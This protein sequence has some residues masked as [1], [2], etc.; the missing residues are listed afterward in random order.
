[1]AFFDLGELHWRGVSNL[2][3]EDFD[4]SAAKGRLDLWIYG[5]KDQLGKVDEE[6]DQAAHEKKKTEDYW[7]KT[8]PKPSGSGVQP[9]FD[10]NTAYLCINQP[11]NV[12]S[13]EENVCL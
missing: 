2:L 10:E 11:I 1:M 3:S 9:K 6:K 8:E 13:N 7:V 12:L 5:N 4:V